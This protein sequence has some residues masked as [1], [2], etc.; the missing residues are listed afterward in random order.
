MNIKDISTLVQQEN[1]PA[2]IQKDVLSRARKFIN[3]GFEV[4]AITSLTSVTLDVY[5]EGGNLTEKL[6]IKFRKAP[7][8]KFNIEDL[9]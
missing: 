6:K 2:P 3:D 9:D 4:E 5:D 7:P 1:V 8:I